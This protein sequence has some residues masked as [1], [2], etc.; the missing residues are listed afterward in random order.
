M[1]VLDASVLIALARGEAIAVSILDLL[2]HSCVSSINATEMI[3]KLNQYG[4]QGEKAFEMLEQSGLHLYGIERQD[5]YYA[6]KIYKTTKAYGLSIADRF[7]LALA[8]RLD[9]RVYTA[10]RAW[11]KVAKVLDLEII[12]IR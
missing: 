1:I 4:V 5:V 6:A 8:K 7:C 11:L 3:Q 2:S 10:D 12:S 9:A